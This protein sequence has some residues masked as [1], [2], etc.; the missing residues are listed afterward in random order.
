MQYTVPS[1]VYYMQQPL[2]QA[3]CTNSIQRV[4]TFHSRLFAV[5]NV[6]AQSS[7]YSK[8]L[9]VSVGLGQSADGLGRIGSQKMDPWTTVL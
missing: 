5:L 7:S 8:E 2:V 9:Q 6:T 1:S 3:Q 4:S